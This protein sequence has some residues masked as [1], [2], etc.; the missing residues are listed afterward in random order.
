MAYSLTLRRIQ[1][2][3]RGRVARNSPPWRALVAL[4]RNALASKARLFRRRWA[5]RER[6]FCDCV[7]ARAAGTPDFFVVQIGAHDGNM[8]DPI[9]KWIE[10]HKWRGVLIEPQRDQFERLRENY[11]GHE[12][13][14]IFEN[15]AIDREA[16]ERT[17]FQVRPDAIHIPEQT[18]LASFF[19]DRALS[20]YAAMGLMV[21]Q[22]VSCVPLAAL[23]QRHR[24]TRIDLLQIDTEGYDH[25]ILKSVDFQAMPPALIRF[26]HRHLAQPELVDCRRLLRRCGYEV[27]ELEFDAVAIRRAE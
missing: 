7:E 2:W 5:A 23:L 12:S 24:I 20:T 6:H 9:R 25:E 14:L 18:G 1:E 17:L 21:G 26:E 8:D 16:G 27:L 10:R 4:K 19:P 11:R 22:R 13:R 3:L 15:V